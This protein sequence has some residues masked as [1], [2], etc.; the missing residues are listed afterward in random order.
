[1]LKTQRKGTHGHVRDVCSDWASAETCDEKRPGGNGVAGPVRPATRSVESGLACSL[2]CSLSCSAAVLSALLCCCTSLS[3]PHGSSRST[4]RSPGVVF[5]PGPDE[6]HEQA[7]TSCRC[8][9]PH[10]QQHL[11]HHDRR[12]HRA[13]REDVFGVLAASADLQAQVRAHAEIELPLGQ[14]ANSLLEAR[15]RSR[16]QRSVTFF[17]ARRL[18]GVNAGL[19]PVLVVRVPKQQQDPGRHRRRNHQAGCQEL[20]LLDLLLRL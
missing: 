11:R 12:R 4:H 20:Q 18:P 2:S 7:R 13:G 17:H 16:R 6:K 5:L 10:E 1:M 9:C 19:D 15:R 3:H 14:P 8:Q